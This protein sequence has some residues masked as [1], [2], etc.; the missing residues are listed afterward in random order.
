MERF[1]ARIHVLLASKEPVGVV[2]RRG[3][4]KQVCTLLWERRKDEFTLAQYIFY[5]IHYTTQGSIR[6]KY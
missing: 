2:L 4:S 5:I 3:P 1:P 6:A